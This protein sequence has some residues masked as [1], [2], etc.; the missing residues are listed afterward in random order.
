M[1]SNVR[2]KVHPS[3][4]TLLL[5]FF[6]FFLNIKA[7]VPYPRTKHSSP[8]QSVQIPNENRITFNNTN[9]IFS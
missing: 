2:N 6:F 4:F 5:R 8:I 3:S 9:Q 7:K 1:Y